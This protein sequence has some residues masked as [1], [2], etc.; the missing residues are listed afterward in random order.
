[1][2]DFVCFFV[3]FI[4][5]AALTQTE[6]TSGNWNEKWVPRAFSRYVLM[7]LIS[8]LIVALMYKSLAW[9]VISHVEG[10]NNHQ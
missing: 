3:F 1:M 5:I 2:F 7:P 10:K 9:V 4:K 8:G 6:R